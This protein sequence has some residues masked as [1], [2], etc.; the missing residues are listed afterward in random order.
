MLR[1]ALTPLCCAVF[2]C[3]GLRSSWGQTFLQATSVATLERAVRLAAGGGT[4]DAESLMA[5]IAAG[6]AGHA[7][8]YQLPCAWKSASKG[9]EEEEEE[10]AVPGGIRRDWTSWPADSKLKGW[11][12]HVLLGAL[13]LVAQQRSDAP[14]R[15]APAD[16]SAEQLARG[17]AKEEAV[18]DK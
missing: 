7:L 13:D 15:P 4:S 16:L 17:A 14:W 9:E 18:L 6:D 11:P 3:A 5:A 8:R 12:A 1:L 10:N 2:T